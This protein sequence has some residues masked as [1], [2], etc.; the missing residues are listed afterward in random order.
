M[1]LG[2][3]THRSTLS[4][5][6]VLAAIILPP[7]A[8]AL[9]SACG[10][11]AAT[12]ASAPSPTSA[13]PALGTAATRTGTVVSPSSA[14]PS[15]TAAV[16]NTGP[17]SASTASGAAPQSIASVPPKAGTTVVFWTN[18]QYPYKDGV[19]A[20]FVTEFGQQGGP[21]IQYTNT[22]YKDFMSKL[23]TTVAAGTPPDLSYIDRYVTQGYACRGALSPLDDMIGRSAVIKKDM[24][25]PRLVQDTTYHGKM[26]AIPNGA[27]VGFLFYNKDSFQAA[28]LDPA[29]PPTTWDSAQS[30]AQKLTRRQGTDLQQVGWSPAQDWGVPW[31]VP[32][33]EEGGDLLNSAE[34]TVTFDDAQAATA[35]DFFTQ[36]YNLQG[37]Y[38][39]VAQF[40]NSG[41]QNAQKGFFA[42]KVAVHWDSFP[43]VQMLTQQKV[44]F[45]WG[46][47]YFP[48]PTGG[49]HANYGGGWG[50]VIPRGAKQPAGAFQFLEFLS[51][52]DAQIRWAAAWDVVPTVSG[53]AQ[54]PA[55]QQ[56]DPV[57]ALAANE[58]PNARF[59]IAAPGG[60]QILPVGTGIMANV[61]SGKQTAKDALAA[62]HRRGGNAPRRHDYHGLGG[63]RLR[64]GPGMVLHRRH[65]AAGGR[66]AAVP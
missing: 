51:K 44:P 66:A 33:W 55:Y 21:T 29:K 30:I 31:M 48:L 57:L 54:S 16:S 41:N 25:F 53:V 19:G 5:R 56:G 61:V 23:L 27:G 22:A 2:R 13:L 36:L 39:E 18:A 4:R 60:D 38:A 24:F 7:C 14:M 45:A 46:T 15:T 10:G 28:G 64:A 49:Q 52:P 6:Q 40:V 62:R 20:Q 32:F 17:S 12:T 58:M 59:V 8:L 50:L 34:T 1:R 35:L 11:A 26:Y 3:G 47:S 63:A 9:L 42:G 43:I 37:S 65:R